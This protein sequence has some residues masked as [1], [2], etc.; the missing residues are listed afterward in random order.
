MISTQGKLHI[1]IYK[2]TLHFKIS[3]LKVSRAVLFSSR[4]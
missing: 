4:W 1:Y 3:Y 2:F